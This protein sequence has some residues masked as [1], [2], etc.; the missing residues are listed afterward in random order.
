VFSGVLD[1]FPGLRVALSEGQIG[2]LPYL[3]ARADRVWADPHDGGTGIRIDRP[4]SSYVKKQIFGC[5]FDDDTALRCRE[6][7]GI[8]QIM[9]E[10][11]FPH[12][13][14]THPNTASFARDMCERAGL[15][16][17]ERYKVFRG[18]AIRLYGLERFG[19]AA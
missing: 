6:M 18:N 9:L 15:S 7:I 12:A 5:I 4:P 11:D 1:R 3:V 17:P 10:V 16:L 14:S 8:D 19:I 13:A 2:W